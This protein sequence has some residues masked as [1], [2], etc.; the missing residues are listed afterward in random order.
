MSKSLEGGHS[1]EG[2]NTCPQRICRVDPQNSM[3]NSKVPHEFEGATCCMTSSFNRLPHAFQPI[4]FI[5]DCRLWSV[6]LVAGYAEK[7]VGSMSE[8]DAMNMCRFQGHVSCNFKQMPPK[9]DGEHFGKPN[10]LS[11]QCVL[12]KKSSCL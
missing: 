1:S 7:M 3:L 8:K 5:S 11:H 2:D 12:S 6:F 10:F 9:T 4:Q